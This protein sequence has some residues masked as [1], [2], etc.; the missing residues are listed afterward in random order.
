[1]RMWK[2]G[3][4]RKSDYFLIL[5]LPCLFTGAG[6]LHSSLNVLYALDVRSPHVTNPGVSSSRL[7]A[8]IELSWITIY[9]TKASLLTQLSFNKPPYAY[10]AIH[11]TRYYWAVVSVCSAAFVFTM[12]VPTITCPH[13][14]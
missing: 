2:K 10:V 9:L 8:A 13:S 6:L 11:L 12:V 5:A 3:R 4:L 14:C 1:V 7:T